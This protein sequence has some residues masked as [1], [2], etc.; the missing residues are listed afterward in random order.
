MMEPRQLNKNLDI[1][2]KPSILESQK[3]VLID[4]VVIIEALKTIKGLER[5]LQAALIETAE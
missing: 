5:K 1:T 4:R 2:K 3:P